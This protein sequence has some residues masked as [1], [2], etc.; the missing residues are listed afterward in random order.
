MHTIYSLL[1]LIALIFFLPYEYF[2]RDKEIRNRWL[3]EKLGLFSINA[4]KKVLWI[5]AVSVGEVNAIVPLVKKIQ[6]EDDYSILITTVTDTGQAIAKRQFDTSVHIAYMPFDLPFTLKKMFQRIKPDLILITETEIWPNLIRS[7]KIYSIP[8]AII[9]GRISE[10]S[11][12]R[13]LKIRFFIESVLKDI[14]IFL[15]QNEVYSQRIIQLGADPSSV[16]VMGN[17]KFDIE[18]SDKGSRWAKR[19][20]GRIIIAG[21]THEPEEQ[22][23]LNAYANVKKI[24]DDVILII[25]PRHPHRFKTVED[26]LLK[27]NIP[28]LKRSQI[29]NDTDLTPIN[30]IL[31]DVMGELS[32]LYKYCDLAILG[33]SFI[34]HGGQN[35]VEPAYW[36]KGI[37][38]GPHMENFY[39]IEDFFRVGAAVKADSASLSHTLVELL[40]NQSRLQMMGGSSKNLIE[41]NRGAVDTTLD[42][43]KDIL[44]KTK[45]ISHNLP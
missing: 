7:A 30:I 24:Y 22:I 3:K 17:L 11:F 25:A 8:I 42:I 31:L 9:N 13:Y 6:H 45:K 23:I 38:C 37:V 32:S 36:G 12:K 44:L 41:F 2:R 21:S 33:G 20:K 10:R 14:D 35:P 1:Y 34:P 5:H 15:M 18:I 16:K 40:S 19:V 28:F 26:I 4:S 27:T 43:I 29:S 39:F